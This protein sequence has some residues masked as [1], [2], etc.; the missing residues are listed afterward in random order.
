MKGGVTVLAPSVNA[1]RFMAVGGRWPDAPP[2]F[3]DEQ[4]ERHVND[5]RN[6][7]G[8][9]VPPVRRDVAARFVRAMQFGGLTEHE[10]WQVTRQK[11]CERWGTA[12]EIM[13]LDELPG[14]RWFRDAWSRSHNGGPIVIDL[15]KARQQQWRRLHAAVTQENKRR[16][17]DLFGAAEIKLDKLTWQKAMVDARDEDELRKVW[18]EGLAA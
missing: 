4:I 16:D 9:D 15:K 5:S 8:T 2:G 10:A 12:C 14:D 1:L 17:L 3:L 18:I 7:D 13:R 6:H 11:D